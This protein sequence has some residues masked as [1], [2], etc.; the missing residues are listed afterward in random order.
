MSAVFS[1]DGRVVAYAQTVDNDTRLCIEPFP[2]T[3]AQ[4]FCLPPNLADS[5][6]HPRWDPE[7]GRLFFDPRLGD[8]ESVPV[9]TPTLQF[10]ARRPESYHPFQLAPPGYRTPYDITKSGRFLGLIT[11]GFEQ[12]ERPVLTRII[13]VRNWFDVLKTKMAQ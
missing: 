1:P 3:N 9:T 7:D 12:Y 13:V 5:P 6:K 11:A 10:G 4:N 2:T 8:F